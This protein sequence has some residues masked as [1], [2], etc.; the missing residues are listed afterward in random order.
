MPSCI[1]YVHKSQGSELDNSS[2]LI[3]AVRIRRLSDEADM[4]QIDKRY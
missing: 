1:V 4:F 2:Y 3:A